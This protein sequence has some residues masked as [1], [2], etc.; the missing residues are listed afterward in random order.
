VVASV[1]PALAD[2]ITD[3]GRSAAPGLW[4]L[5]ASPPR[6]RSR[7]EMSVAYVR[8]MFEEVMLSVT[9]VRPAVPAGPGVEAGLVVLSEDAEPRRTLR[10]IIGQPE[11][12]AI[13]GAWSGAVSPRPGTWDLLVSALGLLGARAE[14][15]VI[16]AV[17][18]R[19]HYY[20]AIDIRRGED[21][22]R[23]DCRVSDA[24]AVALRTPGAT[25]I[26]YERVMAMAASASP[27]LGDA[28]GQV[29]PAPA[30][31]DIGPWPGRP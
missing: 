9:E 12:R 25:I 21:L 29:S 4:A 2:V 1:D 31:D 28:G 6:R 13:L 8:E 14:R 30:V 15:A 27:P 3:D 19:R 17:A 24:I 5:A 16:T 20:G 11:A 23:L 18:D 26:A 10:I 22:L 7:G